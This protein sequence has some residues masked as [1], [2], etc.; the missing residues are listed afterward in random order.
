MAERSLLRTL[1]AGCSAPVGAYAAVEDGV[2]TLRGGAFAT[3]GSQT[4]VD[5]VEGP[6]SDAVELG[7]VLAQQLLDAG[8]GTVLKA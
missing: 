1:E 7:A 6:A 3:D 2:L 4:W 5:H 8:A